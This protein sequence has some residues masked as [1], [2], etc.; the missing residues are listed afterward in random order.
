MRVVI[1]HSCGAK[2]RLFK[3]IIVVEMHMQTAIRLPCGCPIL[4]LLL[5]T[6]L[7]RAKKTHSRAQ[8]FLLHQLFM[9][10]NRAAVGD[11]LTQEEQT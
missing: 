1:L 3:F 8:N 7:P 11:A 10:K 6:A 5:E 2:F 4:G 9:P